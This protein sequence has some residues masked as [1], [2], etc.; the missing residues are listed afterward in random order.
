MPTILIIA[1]TD[2][3]RD[4]RVYRQ[5]KFLRP[6]FR[7][8]TVG[9]KSPGIDDVAFLP[10]RALDH[11]VR[12]QALVHDVRRIGCY[13][14]RRFAAFDKMRLAEFLRD[15]ADLSADLI[16]AND[17]ETLP[18][19]RA[20]QRRSPDTKLIF[21]A[22]EYAPKQHDDRL[23]WRVLHGPYNAFVCREFIPKTD[24]MMT[25]APGFADEYR[26]NFGASPVVIENRPDYVDLAPQPVGD[27]IRL[28]HH[29]IAAPSRHI[30]TMID[31]MGLLDERFELN[32]VL[33]EST[34]GHLEKLRRH[35][36][37]KPRVRF[38]APVPMP[39]LPRFLNQFDV[40]IHF[41]P[42]LSFNARH[43][44]PNKIFE[45]IMAR[46][47]IV[48]GPSPGMTGIVRAFGCGLVADGFSA[49]SGAKALATLDA[50]KIAAYKAKAHAGSMEAS[51]LAEGRTL[52]DLTQ[53]V[54]G[55]RGAKSRRLQ[56]SPGR[57][58]LAFL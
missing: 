2:L 36:R 35:A 32:L 50:R 21:D 22:H 44:V 51:N 14:T 11:Q 25:S 54:L 3:S 15:H 57:D 27:R 56:P 1:Y 55:D 28:V 8:I 18:F 23:R 33:V 49:E 7:L 10:I 20:I 16:I 58:D 5:I 12:R 48:I 40:G 43:A 53:R 9:K 17:A 42:P 39:D 34:P 4:P 38:L 13:L 52:L 45:F 41:L 46:L 29:G 47:A 26:R 19:A 30:D 31:M 6:H 24:A 37:G